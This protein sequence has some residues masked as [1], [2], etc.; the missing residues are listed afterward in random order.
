MKLL[1]ALTAAIL[2]LVANA[3]AQDAEADGAAERSEISYSALRK[4]IDN[5]RVRGATISGDGWWV[6]VSTSD[7]SI[8]HTR[9]TPNTPIADRLVDAGVR[10]E[11]L[12]TDDDEELPLLL[13]LFFNILPLLIFI[14]FFWFVISRMKGKNSDYYSRAEKLNADFLE[15]LEKLLSEQKSS[16]D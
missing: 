5:G 6:T 15:R 14:G 10:T 4:L 7:G 9:V 13:S 8:H 16:D 2:V 1:F 3:A 12:H 11:F